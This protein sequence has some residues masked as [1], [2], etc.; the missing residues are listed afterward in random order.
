MRYAGP[1]YEG[2]GI[3]HDW[4]ASQRAAGMAARIAKAAD[5]RLPGVWALV[6]RFFSWL[7]RSAYDARQRDLERY[8]ATSSDLADLERRMKALERRRTLFF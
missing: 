8:L 4:V 3:I 1:F 5:G 6:E 2:D 7:E